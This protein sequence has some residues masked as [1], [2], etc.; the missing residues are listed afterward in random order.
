MATTVFDKPVGTEIGQLSS[1]TTSNKTNLVNA[2]NS[3]NSNIIRKGTLTAGGICSTKNSWGSYFIVVPFANA[4]KLSSVTVNSATYYDGNNSGT[5]FAVA[6]NS[7]QP[8]CIIFSTAEA[9]AAGSYCLINFTA[10]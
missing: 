5:S 4:D 3:L 1:L 9:N 2:I 6:F 7:K 10:S 8:G